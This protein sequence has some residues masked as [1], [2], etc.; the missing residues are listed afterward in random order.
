MTEMSFAFELE[1]WHWLILA[2]ALA[3]IEILTPGFFFIWLG[4]AALVT[5]IVALVAPGLTWEN[6][7][8]IFALLSAVSVLGWYRFRHRLVIKSD[9]MTLNR[10][11]EQL[12]GRNATLSE[13]IVNG[14]GQI[15]I[16]DTVWRCEGEDL[17]AGTKVKVVAL[18]GAI[19]SVEKAG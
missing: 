19:V 7:V 9:D 5:S 16:D 12:L 6:Q 3:G 14:R 18:R 11:G 8:L 1:F 17:D 2:A 15:K 10:R 13:P 4:A